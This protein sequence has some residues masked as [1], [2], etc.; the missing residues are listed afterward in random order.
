MK[1]KVI[2]ALLTVAI[3][4]PALADPPNWAPA[5]GRRDH[6]RRDWQR[7]RDDWRNYRNYDWNR[8]DKRHGRYD[9][10]RYYRDGRY[11]KQRRL[12]YN[13]RIYRGDNGRYYCRRPDGTT[14]L[15]IGAVGGG[16][17]GNVIAPGDS[18]TL[19]TIVGGGLGAVLG[20]AIERDGVSCR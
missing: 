15:I 3:A 14:G 17:L 8:P 2:A 9:A 5:H 1:G 6:D 13:D 12:S 4:T 18:K 7:D 19:G 11:Y 10:E 20:R 16:V